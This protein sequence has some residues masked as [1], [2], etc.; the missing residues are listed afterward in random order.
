M[1]DDVPTETAPAVN[2]NGVEPVEKPDLFGE[3]LADDARIW[4]VYDRVAKE[5]DERRIATWNRGLDNLALFAGLFSAVTTAFIIESQSDMKPNYLQLTFQV[6]NATA[7]QQTFVP[8]PFVVPSSARTVNSLWVGS[9]VLSLSAALIAIM[10]KD[11]IGAYASRPVC[12]LRQWAEM[13]SYRLL[14]VERWYMSGVIAAAPVL[15]HVSLVLFGAGLVIFISDDSFTHHLTLGLCLAA[16]VLYIVV[17]LSAVVFSASPFKSPATQMMRTTISTCFCFLRD[18]VPR[19]KRNL[20]EAL[21]GSIWNIVAPGLDATSYRQRLSRR[22]GLAEIFWDLGLPHGTAPPRRRPPRAILRSS[23][24]ACM[25]ALRAVPNL[26]MTA[27]DEFRY[28][29]Q[30]PHDKPYL[31][32]VL[33]L[34]RRLRISDA[35][36]GTAWTDLPVNRRPELISQSL[37]WLSGASQ[38]PEVFR[39]VLFALGDLEIGVQVGQ[40]A[41]QG[42]Q[43]RVR[44]E[45][46]EHWQTADFHTLSRYV[47]A[48][49]N[50]RGNP[51][52]SYLQ[53]RERFDLEG[54]PSLRCEDGLA[55]IVRLDP[56]YIVADDVATY[57]PDHISHPRMTRFL[58]DLITPGSHRAAEPFIVLV[59]KYWD[60]V[61]SNHAFRLERELDRRLS[62]GMRKGYAAKVDEYGGKSG[63]VELL[64]FLCGNGAMDD[65]AVTAAIELVM[66]VLEPTWLIWE[67][68]CLAYLFGNSD[69]RPFAWAGRAWSS[70]QINSLSRS[71]DRS[72]RNTLYAVTN[73]TSP[74]AL[75]RRR[76][77]VLALTRTVVMLLARQGPLDDDECVRVRFLHAQLCHPRSLLDNDERN[78][79][80]RLAL[81]ESALTGITI[82][83]VFTRE[84]DAEA[85]VE[86]AATIIR[87]ISHLLRDADYAWEGEELFGLLALVEAKPTEGKNEPWDLGEWIRNGALSILERFPETT[88]AFQGLHEEL[89]AIYPLCAQSSTVAHHWDR[90]GY[91]GRPDDTAS[92]LYYS[93]DFPL[94]TPI[95]VL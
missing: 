17:T 48:D 3:E 7:F 12:N 74:E 59:N 22:A 67:H 42:L 90:I 65:I 61:M 72:L 18:T 41:P 56:A 34:Y 32:S 54:N 93:T 64:T 36:V 66:H 8:E 33:S 5:D 28:R 94:P 71:L 21:Q 70:D 19:P 85:V 73:Q 51:V 47:L 11:W 80:I 78:E 88:P 4:R 27:L 60:Y 89:V 15:L 10:G 43:T 55:A 75:G 79:V 63:S 6:L 14:C 69:L 49:R 2:S 35:F 26:P 44:A 20:V 1:P 39:A 87:H 92:L 57:A 68:P 77:F 30:R 13:R 46:R 24:E 84:P 52:L 62:P 16:G 50:F 86:T 25:A 38:A 23:L 45:I 91:P 82:T 76:G 40:I 31:A 53:F 95:L 58:L 83:T 29:R 9:L 37:S 81:E